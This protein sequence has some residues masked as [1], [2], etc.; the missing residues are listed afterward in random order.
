MRK[1]LLLLAAIV[2][3]FL[4]A[5]SRAVDE[6]KILP[7]RVKLDTTKSDKGNTYVE[8]SKIV[9]K[10][11]VSSSSFSE[12]TNVIVKYNIFYQVSELGRTGD[13]EVK[14]STGSHA[15]PSL[16][17]NRPV[18]FETDPINLAKGA[19]DAGWYFDNGASPTIRDKVVGLWFKAFDSTGKQIGEY[20]NPASVT[21]KRKWKD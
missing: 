4:P 2:P 9:Y 1:F 5:A 20:T 7:S 15:I 12:L 10:V 13:P 14:L 17:T 16:R 11:E 6:I 21:Q 19:L 8:S 18:E 3:A